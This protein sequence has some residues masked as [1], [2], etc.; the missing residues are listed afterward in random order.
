MPKL[1]HKW[2]FPGNKHAWLLICCNFLLYLVKTAITY[3]FHIPP[4]HRCSS[5]CPCSE[6]P[7]AACAGPCVPAL[8]A[9]RGRFEPRMLHCWQS[10]W[11]AT[12][13][14][15]PP[16]QDNGVLE[17]AGAP[18]ALLWAVSP[19]K[20]KRFQVLCQADFV[21]SW[22]VTPVKAEVQLKKSLTQFS[23]SCLLWWSGGW[24]QCLELLKA[25]ESEEK[26]ALGE[27]ES[28]GGWRQCTAPLGFRLSGI[29]P[30]GFKDQLKA[31]TPQKVHMT[32]K[33][34]KTKDN[35]IPS[36]PTLLVYTRNCVAQHNATC[37]WIRCL[38]SW[39]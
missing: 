3:L 35:T 29:S 5:V 11:F 19:A 38:G 21:K 37:R 14:A 34:P 24:E 13:A 32:K 25:T 30:L 33:T 39:I 17:A 6:H 4:Q 23:L 31:G 1:E 28:Q 27:M 20:G 12:D 10:Y 36:L 7:G 8:S 16:A 26:K 22:T 2:F 15:L 18:K 9:V